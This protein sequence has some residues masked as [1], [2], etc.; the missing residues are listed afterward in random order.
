VDRL[1]P[2]C[3]TLVQRNDFPA[4]LKKTLIHRWLISGVAAAL[5]PSGFKSRGVLTL[6]G[7]QSLGKT[8]WISALVPDPVLREGTIKLDHHLDAGNKDS[9][10]TAV[11]H[12]IVEIGELDSSFKKDV[13]RL[14]GFLTGDRD[15]VRRPYGRADSEYPRRT[16]FT[17]T[18]N[19]N[20]FLVDATGN[21]RW[22]VIPV[23]KI[24]Y[25]HNIDMQ[26]LWAQ[27]A[28]DFHAGVPWW[29]TQ[30]EEAQ[31]EAQNREHRS[32]S[33]IR[34][35]VLEILDLSRKD[36]VGLPALTPTQL[37]IKVGINNPSNANCKECA[38]VLRE[39]LG[40]SSR[41]KIQGIVKWRIPLSHIDYSSALN[42]IGNTSSPKIKPSVDPDDYY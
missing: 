31:L 13:A 14:K 41:V 1:N 38:S 30:E 2:F 26:Q 4:G 40:D 21:S 25:E 20:E 32:I 27:M 35:R 7:K 22:W 23:I 6:Q 33:V 19:D 37:L 3:D 18:V 28:V 42:T 9:L 39:C 24:H 12:W 36:D 10:I 29:L 34:E 11:S 16:V 15:K 8:S 17:A 5:K